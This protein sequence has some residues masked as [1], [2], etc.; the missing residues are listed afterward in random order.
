MTA[1]T[2]LDRPHAAG[3]NTL[4]TLK[5]IASYRELL[6]VGVG[7]NE[8]LKVLG[9]PH[10]TEGGAGITSWSYRVPPF[11]ADNEMR[12]TYV[13]GVYPRFTNGRLAVLHFSYAEGP[14]ET[15]RRE[16]VLPSLDS[17]GVVTLKLF[18]VKED[19]FPGA[20]LIDTDAMPKLGYVGPS[21]DMEVRRL[22]DVRLEEK[23]RTDSESKRHTNWLFAISLTPEDARRFEALTAANIGRKLLLTVG[24][25][26]IMAPRVNE[27]ITQG[28]LALTCDAAK[29]HQLKADLARL[30]R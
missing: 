27:P 30:K 6:P 2:S 8:V 20:R 5:S 4:A 12:G 19:N 26:P 9:Q 16:D 3:S 14:T 28:R 25:K 17:N 13:T 22:T 18:A 15:I 21:P 24:D 10:R 7:T 11:P 23:V 1:Q 29:R